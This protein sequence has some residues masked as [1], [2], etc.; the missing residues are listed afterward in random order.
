MIQFSAA[1]LACA[2]QPGFS[3]LIFNDVKPPTGQAA[4]YKQAA[5][6]DMHEM[7]LSVLTETSSMA[8]SL[9]VARSAPRWRPSRSTTMGLTAG[10]GLY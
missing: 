1:A 7:G 8:N 3:A 5:A 4:A 10:S 9:V 6:G 2:R